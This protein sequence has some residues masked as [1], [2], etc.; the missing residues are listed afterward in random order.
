MALC[1]SADPLLDARINGLL[2]TVQW[3]QL[4]LV[5]SSK[6]A[7]Q[8][9][10]ERLTSAANSHILYNNDH[11][12]IHQFFMIMSEVYSAKKDSDVSLFY[13]LKASQALQQKEA[14]RKGV[15]DSQKPMAIQNLN[16]LDQIPE[17][18]ASEIR[19]V[20][21]LHETF[22][23]AELAA[24]QELH[25]DV[26]KKG[27][28]GAKEKVDS[29]FSLSSRVLLHYFQGLRHQNAAVAST[30][31]HSKIAT[32]QKICA[33]H[34][35]FKKNFVPYQQQCCFEHPLDVARIA[36][37]GPKLNFDSSSFGWKEATFQPG[38]VCIQWGMLKEESFF[39]CTGVVDGPL[40]SGKISMHYALSDSGVPLEKGKKID[41]KEMKPTAHHGNKA[42]LRKDV[43]D[44]CNL[45]SEIRTA[46][47][48]E[49]QEKRHADVSGYTSTAKEQNFRAESQKAA[50]EEL[51]ANISRVLGQDEK[52]AEGEE[53]KEVANNLFEKDRM[54]N[55][56]IQIESI[57]S[58]GKGICTIDLDLWKMF[59]QLLVGKSG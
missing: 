33:I 38:F 42:L 59:N 12:R 15:W 50:V 46:C 31:H 4:P 14:L 19:E 58:V 56:I 53:L 3:A 5:S 44:I 45:A 10:I 18:V 28:K 55:A 11:E 16:N 52:T 23:K 8:K 24:V 21:E 32:D 26:D 1:V 34:N 27:K 51:I 36:E 39:P 22:Q 43:V 57:F 6:K 40:L 2:G 30:S 29:E 25:N 37:L 17:Y 54:F 41:F 48:E 47:E 20:Y 13:L 9:I 35:F 49:E 7:L